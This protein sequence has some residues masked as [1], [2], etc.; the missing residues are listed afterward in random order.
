LPAPL[1]PQSISTPGGE[2]ESV[3]SPP[4]ADA[5]CPPLKNVAGIAAIV[6][7]PSFPGALATDTSASAV[8]S[9]ASAALTS[10]AV[11]VIVPPVR[12]ST[13]V[14][15]VPATL[16]E[17]EAVTPGSTYSTEIEFPPEPAVRAV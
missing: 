15:A 17:S 11:L 9:A 6:P 7:D 1:E 14:I 4:A 5:A 13:T 8:A 3:T 12:P 16:T 10:A 2:V